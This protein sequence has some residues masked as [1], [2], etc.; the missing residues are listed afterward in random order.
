[1]YN[2][3]GGDKKVKKFVIDGI[4]GFE[5]YP[6][7]LRNFLEEANGEEITIDIASP[8]GFV[9]DGLEMHNLIRDYSRKKNSVTIRLIGLAASMASY[10]A[11]A[12]NRVI[13]EDN[14][15][16]M[17]HNV[18]SVVAGDY[19]K[20]QKEAN[21]M[22]RLT[23]R[24][25][26]AYAYRSKKPKKYIRDLMDAETFFFG[27]EMVKEGFVDEIIKTNKNEPKSEMLMLAKGQVN[28]CFEKMK[29]SIKT[30]NDIKKAAQMI[31]DFSE[32]EYDNIFDP[33]MLYS[34]EHASR[35]REPNSFEKESFRRKKLDKPEL[36]IISGQ[37]NK[38]EEKKMDKNKLKI[39]YPEVYNEIFQDGVKS[40]SEQIDNIKA[41]LEFS[42][43]A[44][45]EVLESIKNN[46]KFSTLHAARYAKIQIM[47]EIKQNRADDN[48]EELKL[49]K[50]NIG[51]DKEDTEKAIKEFNQ[52]YGKREGVKNNG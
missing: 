13:A 50:E 16:Y 34:N 25:A 47:N 4:I 48:P 39:E 30:K 14:A 31:G 49:K 9:Y 32:N 41:F 3:I 42:D 8:G 45:K 35:I 7:K 28:N 51:N 1:L 37:N 33:K 21:D 20:M 23:D 17:I 15:V 22:E 40:V 26:R 11:L 44:P 38:M 36:S 29:E 2:I 27:D 52:L 10:I 12:G 43:I 19:R 5:S 18:F 46:E 24:F 6:A